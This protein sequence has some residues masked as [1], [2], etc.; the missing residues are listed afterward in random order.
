[1]GIF[2]NIR[3]RRVD[4][5]KPLL[6]PNRG[7]VP[8]ATPGSPGAGLTTPANIADN[9]RDQEAERQQNIAQG[10]T[11]ID[12]A[13]GRFDDNYYQ[14]FANNFLNYYFPQID[15]QYQ[16][17]SG[18]SQAALVNRGIDQSTVGGGVFSNLL[19]ERTRA[20]T[21]VANNAASATQGLRGNVERTKTDLYNLNESAAD[22]AAANARATAE[23]TALVAP[24][25]VGPLGQIFSAA[26]MP[27]M[28]GAQAYRNRAPAPYTSPFGGN[29][30]GTVVR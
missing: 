10:R 25:T 12:E 24:P 20:R 18:K 15:E 2:Q 5:G 29:G 1:M 16:N 4:A 7:T 3:Q 23:A 27:A 13:F 30:S 8:T 22:P 28:Y 19:R 6:F 26:M 17:A 9:L 21:D 14:G 11:K